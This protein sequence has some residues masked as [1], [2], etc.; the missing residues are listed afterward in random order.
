MDFCW[1]AF[2]LC[3]GNLIALIVLCRGP[4][5]ALF[6]L[7][8]ESLIVLSRAMPKTFQDLSQCHAEDLSMKGFHS[9]FPCIAKDLS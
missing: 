5:I 8:Q 1:T 3:Q 9:N 4:F 7:Y 2:V 6:L